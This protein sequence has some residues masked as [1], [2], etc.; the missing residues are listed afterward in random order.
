MLTSNLIPAGKIIHKFEQMKRLKD[1]FLLLVAIFS[2]FL[3]EAQQRPN[4]IFVLTDDL[5]YSDLSAY[6][7]PVIRTPFLDSVASVGIK[8]TNYV[9]TSPSCTPS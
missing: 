3:L 1:L 7:N 9:V 2:A 5:G 8:A 6:G 4:I